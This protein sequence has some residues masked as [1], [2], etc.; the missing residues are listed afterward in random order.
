M[1]NPL[2]IALDP[3]A[4]LASIDF[5]LG[6]DAL[7]AVIQFLSSGMSSPSPSR[8]GVVAAL[9][10]RLYSQVY[11]Q[12]NSLS[13]SQAHTMLQEGW[14]LAAHPRQTERVST[15]L[16]DFARQSSLVDY[17]EEFWRRDQAD[18]GFVELLAS[19]PA[20]EGDMHEF[21]VDASQFARLLLNNSHTPMSAGYAAFLGA[22]AFGYIHEQ[23]ISYR[24]PGIQDEV[25]RGWSVGLGL[26]ECN[27]TVHSSA[28]KHRTPLTVM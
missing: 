18:S 7:P 17:P 4:S 19:C 20:S 12:L 8:V 5:K 21:M 6:C 3:T 26:Q 11:A 27:G 2:P 14:Q 25:S 24:R 22:H 13:R 9:G 10:S 16:S 28:A 1:D 15:W 23:L